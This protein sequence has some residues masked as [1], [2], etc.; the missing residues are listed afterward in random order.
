MD[1]LTVIICPLLFVFYSIMGLMALTHLQ[2]P[3]DA[4]TKAINY[5]EQLYGGVFGAIVTI[6]TIYLWIILLPASLLA[7]KLEGKSLKEAGYPMD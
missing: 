7:R 3:E 2:Y 5:L 6:L 4:V 1:L